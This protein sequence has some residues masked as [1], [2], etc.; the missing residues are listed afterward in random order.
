MDSVACGDELAV[1]PS[2]ALLHGANEEKRTVVS[3]IEQG[4]AEDC[5]ADTGSVVPSNGGYIQYICVQ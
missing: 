3:V 5:K 1:G 4:A 2:N